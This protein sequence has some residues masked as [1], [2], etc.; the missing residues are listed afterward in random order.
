M[1][2]R[3]YTAPVA[4]QIRIEE[5]NMAQRI[6]FRLAKGKNVAMPFSDEDEVEQWAN[7]HSLWEE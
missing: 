2:T 7:T 1:K 5:K 6:S 4:E 3:E